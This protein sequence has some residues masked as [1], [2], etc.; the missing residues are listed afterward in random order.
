MCS[1]TD[2]WLT[3]FSHTPGFT[4]GRG[5]GNRGVKYRNKKIVNIGLKKSN[6]IKKEKRLISDF[7]YGTYVKKKVANIGL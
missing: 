6:T 7:L 5:M 2:S 1:V 4:W 3:Q